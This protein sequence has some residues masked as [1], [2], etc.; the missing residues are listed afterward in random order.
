MY[1]LYVGNYDAFCFDHYEG[2]RTCLSIEMLL[3]I[4]G[5]E[6]WTRKRA[7]KSYA[8]PKGFFEPF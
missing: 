7:H 8:R 1:V 3:V 5:P 2:L 4:Y 6:A